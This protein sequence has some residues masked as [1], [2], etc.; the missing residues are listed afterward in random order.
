MEPMEMLFSG[1]GTYSYQTTVATGTY[2]QQ[3]SLNVTASDLYGFTAYGNIDIKVIKKIIATAEPEQEDTHTV[4]NS[5]S[6][7]TL[8]ISF[9]LDSSKTS[10]YGGFST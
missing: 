3:F 8:V 2:I 5:L 7:Q 6:S 1:D 9:K 4:T 10:K